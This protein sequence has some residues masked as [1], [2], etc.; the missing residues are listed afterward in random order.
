MKALA[1]F[2]A[3]REVRL[4]DQP[5]PVIAGPTEVKLRILEAGI[6]GTDREITSFHYGTP[7]ANSP[8]LV[9]GHEALGEVVDVGSGVT[10]LARGDLAVLTVRRPCPHEICAPCRK[11]RQDFCITGDFTE[12]GIKG[13]H[14]FMTEF[15]VDDQRYIVKVPKDLRE[16]AVLLEPLTVAEKAGEQARVIAQ[17]L[18]G[19]LKNDPSQL[20]AL[21]LGAGPIGLLGAMK[22]A[23]AK[24]NTWVY[25][26][27]KA[28][29]PNVKIV[30]AIGARF[31]SSA[32]HPPA[33]LAKIDRQYRRGVR[34][35]RRRQDF[36]RGVECAQCERNFY[37]HRGSRIEGADRDRCRRDHAQ[38]RAQKPGP[39]RHR[40]CRARLF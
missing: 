25:S 16:V 30:S 37:V 20:N 23:N 32:E 36:L 7:P 2:P 14:G 9:I 31:L 5:E 38:P 3:S 29:S 34:G 1:V 40:Q 13:A 4:I 22:L 24:F 35:H 33:E 12:R 17:R 21:V 28:D 27:D 6:C 15:V 18:P 26:L 19:E 11:G 10:G 8:H 39:P